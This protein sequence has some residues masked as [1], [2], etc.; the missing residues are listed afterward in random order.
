MSA[1][2]HRTVPTMLLRGLVTTQYLYQK[3]ILPI[4]SLQLFLFLHSIERTRLP[5]MNAKHFLHIH[6][7]FLTKRMS[8]V[9]KITVI[10]MFIEGYAAV[11]HY[12]DQIQ[13][14]FSSSHLH[15]EDR[16]LE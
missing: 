4:L 16:S 1:D 12:S 9:Q 6:A 10:S 3:R 5:E 15:L 2:I 13:V 7:V 11:V 14:M 8:V